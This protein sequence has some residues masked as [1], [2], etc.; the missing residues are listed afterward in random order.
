M[1]DK[2]SKKRKRLSNG[3]SSPNKKATLDREGAIRI[4]LQDA[5]G[6]HPVLLSSPGLA[7]PD[8][9]FKA[10]S[11]ALSTRDADKEDAAPRTHHVV[12]HSQ[13]HPRLDFTASPI[14]LDNGLS[15]YVAVYDPTTNQLQL[16]QAHHL[17][18]RS[19]LRSEKSAEDGPKRSYTQQRQELGREFGT[20][21]AKKIIADKT[22][23]AIINRDP[24][25]KGKPSDIQNAVM[26][27]MPD[28]PPGANDEDELSASLASKPIPKP[29]LH[30]GTIEE[31]Y[32]FTL[33]V[34]P[35]EARLLD[36]KEWQEKTRKGE[37]I[38]F[39]HRFPAFRLQHL[40]QTEQTQRLKALKYLHL[41]LTFH[42]A[43]PTSS[44]RTGR[45]V[46]KKDVLDKKLAEWPAS[47]VSHVR[48]R[49][50]S[51]DNTLNTW[52]MHNLYCHMCALS[53]FVDGWVT[54]TRNLKD[55]LRMEAKELQQY[56]KELGARVGPATEGERER[57][58]GKKGEEKGIRV[59][60]L[61][62][63]LEFPKARRRG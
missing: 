62:L 38:N 20:K 5:S 59:A 40:V 6:G 33:L 1:A 12:L 2:E 37:G 17:S 14:A 34:P 50:A 27:S 35:A 13:Q 55:D 45:K 31:V 49:F 41:L 48:K 32:P 57:F 51:E 29:N 26:Q 53:L 42:D 58:G 60:K 28:L 24:K 46:P 3:V 43:L 8:Q 7:T 30:A 15:H 10:Y 63:P 36:I 16:I 19:T 56:F 54:D 4:T 47:L 44:S 9:S 18:L 61:R 23:N 11:K 22:V 25:G 21:K 39:S 52:H